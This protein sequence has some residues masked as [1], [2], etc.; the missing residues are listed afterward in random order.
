MAFARGVA[1]S[2]DIDHLPPLVSFADCFGAV[3]LRY[4]TF[5]VTVFILLVTPASEV[6]SLKNV[7]AY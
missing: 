7:I 4:T 2:F 6:P 1:A 5:F 3:R